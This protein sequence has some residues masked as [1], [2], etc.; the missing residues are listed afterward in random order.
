MCHAFV[1]SLLIINLHYVY[2]LFKNLPILSY[3]DSIA[4]EIKQSLF[5]ITFYGNPQPM[6]FY[7]TS[8]LEFIEI[9]QAAIDHYGYSREEFLNMTIRDIRPMEDLEILNYTL[10]ELSGPATSKRTFRHMLKDGTINH[11]QVVSYPVPYKGHEARLV[12]TTD[13]TESTLYI[14]RFELIAQAT[15][16]AVWDWNLETNAIWWNQSFLDLFGYKKEEVELTADSWTSRIHPD[17]K[18]RVQNSIHQ[19]IQSGEKNWSDEYR[20]LRADRSYAFIID[21]GYTIFK[22]GKAVRMVGSMLDTTLQMQLQTARDESESLLQKI[23]GAAPTALWMSDTEGNLV[24]VNQTWIDWS[25]SP[26]FGNLMEGWVT[27]IHEEDREK[28]KAT[29]LNAHTTC[30]GYSIDYRIYFTD[31]SIR[32]LTS[33]ANPRYDFLNKF[34]GLVG[35]CTD[36]TRQKHLELQKGGFISTVSH[37]LKTPIASLKGYEQL[38]SRSKAVTDVKGINFLN[39][40]G[41][42]ISRLDTL[43]QDL[44]DVSRIESGKLTFKESVFEMNT[45]MAELITDLQQVFPSHTLMLIENQDC[46]IYA[47]RNR[48]IQLITNLIDNAVKYSPGAS[49]V[50]IKAFC[51]EETLTVSVQDFGKGILKE[52]EQYIFERFY[53]VNNVYKAPGLGIGLY[54]CREIINR[55]NGKIWFESTAQEGTTFYFNLPR[56]LD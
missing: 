21:R 40:M 39:R 24:Y 20:F 53:Q 12:M 29:Y 44:L 17:D 28:V 18:E 31:G 10:K 27:I 52:Q 47:D 9:N 48:M 45:L 26:S 11:V 56:K 16:D 36:I 30:S 34:M 23:T 14:E 54:V 25:N 51:N 3:M 38:L 43:V 50:L 37:E 49:K 35:S 4:P 2:T 42:Q 6:W 32:W 1:M 41:V 46:N 33:T 55:M 8:S 22:E 13:L 15:H 19:A 7:D 5:D